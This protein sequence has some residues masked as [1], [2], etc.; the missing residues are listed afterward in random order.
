MAQALERRRIIMNFSTPPAPEDMHAVAI[1]VLENFPDELSVYIEDMELSIE[2]FAPREA[3]DDLEI[4]NEYD[5]LGLYRANA[6]K[7]PGVASKSANDAKRLYLFRRP[8]LDLWCDTNEDLVALMR[9]V[10][11]SEIAQANGFSD[12]EIETFCAMAADSSQL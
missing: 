7:I 4:D 10:I 12:E 6:E 3:L 2:E 8:I 11:I 5:L 1:S 9:N